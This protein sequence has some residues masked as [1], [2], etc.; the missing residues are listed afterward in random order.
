MFGD[1]RPIGIFDSG[2]G[3]LTVLKAAHYFLPKEDLIYF[4]DTAHVPYGSKST[5][6][7]TAYSLEIARFLVSKN[8]KMLIV[9]CNTA[10]ALA[11]D[12]LRREIDVPVIGVI[13]PSAVMAARLTLGGKIGVIG[14]E[15]TVRSHS[16]RDSIK[17]FDRRIKVYELACP[18]LVPLV[19]EGMWHHEV[20]SIIAHEYFYPLR[21]KCIDTLILGCTHYPVIKHIIQHAIGYDVRMIDTSQAIAEE[22]LK[23]LIKNGLEKKRGKG[24]IKVYASDDPARFGRLAANIVGKPLG[25]VLLKKFR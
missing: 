7:V 2:L 11:L 13:E 21:G 22:A 9:A 25:K 18:L 1:T 23:C 19:E 12:S 4:G 5:E 24:S 17:S 10:T 3:G 8:I 15:A 16:Y 14:T 6:T 20:T